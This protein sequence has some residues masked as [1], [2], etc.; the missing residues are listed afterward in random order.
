MEG[1]LEFWKSPDGN[2]WYQ[3]GGKSSVLTQSD[4]EIIEYMT[5][6]LVS[7][8]PSSMRVLRQL[9]SSSQLNKYHYEFKI[10]KRFLSCNFGENNL[11][12]FDIDDGKINFEEVSCPLR[13]ECE[14]EG[15]ICKPT[16]Q[17]P[18]KNEEGKAA[19]LFVRGYRMDEIAKILN[20]S[21]NT[22]HAQID[23]VRK[24]LKLK[25]VKDL[26]KTFHMYNLV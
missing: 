22:V 26:I 23:N 6:I 15:I 12:T 21:K 25:S 7:V 19:M 18:F 1:K 8:Y 11:L 13:G 2:I 14:L 5:N 20:K 3:D 24:K 17:L 9:Y 16:P 4:R 10:V